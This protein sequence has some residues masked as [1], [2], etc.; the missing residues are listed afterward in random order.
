MDSS[1]GWVDRASGG[2]DGQRRQLGA[3]CRTGR[4]GQGNPMGGFKL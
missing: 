4:L 3:G 1:G 2:F